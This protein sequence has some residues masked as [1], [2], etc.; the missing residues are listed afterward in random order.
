MTL[1]MSENEMR[2]HTSENK[3][4]LCLSENEMRLQISENRVRLHI[5]EIRLHT[6]LK[7]NWDCLY[8]YRKVQTWILLNT[9]LYVFLFGEVMLNGSQ[10][11]MRLQ[12]TCKDLAVT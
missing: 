1:K 11:C 5:S 3:I 12:N 10:Y 7:M 8:T 4:K 2:L 6:H 9:I